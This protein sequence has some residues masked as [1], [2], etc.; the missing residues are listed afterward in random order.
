MFEAAEVGNAIDK[1]TYAAEVPKVREALLQVQRDLAGANL[2]VVVVMGG[3]EGAG[4][5]ETI[6]LLPPPDPSHCLLEER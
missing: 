5:T 2:S 6:N 3:V 1:K 4:K